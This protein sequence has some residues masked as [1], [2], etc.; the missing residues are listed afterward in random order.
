MHTTDRRGHPSDRALEMGLLPIATDRNSPEQRNAIIRIL[1]VVADRLDAGETVPSGFAKFVASGLREIASLET[2][3][4]P[5]GMR[6]TRGE[7]KGRLRET[8]KGL[9]R[10]IRVARL[11]LDGKTHGAAVEQVATEDHLTTEAVESAWRKHKKRALQD[12]RIGVL[13]RGEDFTAKQ[14]RFLQG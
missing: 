12:L 13:W 1:N 11:R 7:K 4:A 9:V 2:L 5:F 3:H 14:W 10:A 8:E 6:R